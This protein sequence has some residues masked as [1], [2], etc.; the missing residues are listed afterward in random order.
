MFCSLPTSSRSKRKRPRDS[1]VSVSLRYPRK[2]R[3][4][5]GAKEKVKVCSVQRCLD[6]TIF[7]ECSSDDV[8]TSVTDSSTQKSPPLPQQLRSCS[9][10]G[11]EEEM[12]ID[13][14]T[15]NRQKSSP[16][17][18][19]SR[20]NESVDAR[21]KTT[22]NSSQYSVQTGEGSMESLPL[23]RTSPRFQKDQQ[24]GM[25][26]LKKQEDLKATRRSP[27]I[28][29]TTDRYIEEE[30]VTEKRNVEPQN[31][32]SPSSRTAETTNPIWTVGQQEGTGT[33]SGDQNKRNIDCPT[34]SFPLPAE[35]EAPHFSSTTTKGPGDTS[36]RCSYQSSCSSTVVTVDSNT[37]K[38]SL[39]DKERLSNALDALELAKPVIWPVHADPSN[40]EMKS[41]L[42]QKLDEVKVFVHNALHSEGYRGM[43]E[44]SAAALYV[45]GVP[46]IG[47]TTAVRCCCEKAILE[48]KGDCQP[49]LCH[50]NAG[51]L[52]SS[53][54]PDI[55]VEKIKNETGLTPGVL[56]HE[57]KMLLLIVDEIDTLL[58]SNSKIDPPASESEHALSMLLSW[59]DDQDMHMALIGISNA[60]GDS[61]FG[62]LQVMQK[63]S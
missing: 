31:A 58:S 45:C 36:E 20:I 32:S 60:T 5:E 27:R 15:H 56:K 17:A 8:E 33:S 9:L 48:F 61:I 7:A 25:T 55:L 2:K 34:V 43:K 62:R 44:S 10:F 14:V 37:S 59:A 29:A 1:P 6:S 63:V 49:K 26:P 3:K 38:K 54:T 53:T 19:D 52:S 41:V 22:P 11:S 40:P 42:A 39:D 35:Q 21:A 12:D 24:I 23:R 13:E 18:R 47:K 57:G 30:P 51:H 46:G 50:I 4:E 28:S 16:K